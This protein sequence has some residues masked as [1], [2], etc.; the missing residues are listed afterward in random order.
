MEGQRYC[1]ECHC[2][3]PGHDINCSWHMKELWKEA[4]KSPDNRAWLDGL[5]DP[6]PGGLVDPCPTAKQGWQ[7]PKCKRIYSPYEQ[8]CVWC[9]WVVNQCNKDEED[10]IDP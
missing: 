6:Q 4:I 8:S 2:L 5:I 3:L 10:C 7:C 9:S 1:D